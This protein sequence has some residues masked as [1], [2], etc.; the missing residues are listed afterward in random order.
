[1]PYELSRR[2]AAGPL[3]LGANCSVGSSTF[4]EVL[5][6]MQ[7]EATSLSPCIQPN[8]ASPSRL[9]EH[10]IDL[11]APSCMADYSHRMVDASPC[12][13]VVAEVH[14]AIR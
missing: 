9:G 11:S 6:Q 2:L 7:T 13:E 3:P 12:F 10:L 8:A 5:A 4:Y 14:D 1:M